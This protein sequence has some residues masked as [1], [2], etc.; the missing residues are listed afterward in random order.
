MEDN[1]GGVQRKTMNYDGICQ[2]FFPYP[3]QSFKVRS[4]DIGVPLKEQCLQMVLGAQ[5]CK[6]KKTGNMEENVGEVERKIMNLG[7]I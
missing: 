3:R 4:M 2:E 6:W 1:V 7:D 5:C